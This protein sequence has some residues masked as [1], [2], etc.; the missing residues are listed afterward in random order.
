MDTDTRAENLADLIRFGEHP[1][2]IAA[3]L[4]VIEGHPVTATT[5]ER[6]ATRKHLHHYAAYLGRGGLT[7]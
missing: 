6:W 7:P 3:R 2:R 5:L 1:D 4:S